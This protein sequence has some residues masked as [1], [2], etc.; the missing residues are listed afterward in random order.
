MRARMGAK[1]KGRTKYYSYYA[2]HTKSCDHYGKSIKKAQIEGE[3]EDLLESLR[4]SQGLIEIATHMF[5]T[6]WDKHHASFKERQETAKRSLK[7]IDPRR[8]QRI[9]EFRFQ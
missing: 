1:S 6:L 8:L 5:T 2:C 7:G 3:F 4:P 9:H